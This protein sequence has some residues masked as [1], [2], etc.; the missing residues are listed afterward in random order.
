[1]KWLVREY[2][3]WINKYP[4]NRTIEDLVNNGFIILDKPK[5]LTSRAVC[6]QLKMLFNIKKVGHVGTLDQNATGVLPILLNEACKLA[7][8]LKDMDKKY[9]GKM[10][11]HKNVKT[12]EIE[13]VMNKFIGKIKQIPPLRSAVKR[14][15]RIRTIYEMKILK[16]EHKFITF[17][18]HCEAGT[19]IRKLVSDIGNFIGGAHLQELDRIAVNGFEKNISHSLK[20]VRK[21]WKMCKEDKIRE[22]I[23]PMEYSLKN[24]KKVIVKSTA[25]KNIMNGS[26]IYHAGILRVEESVKK[27]D[28]VAVLSPNGAVIAIGIAQ[29]DAKFMVRQ[30]GLMIK[31]DRVI[32][33]I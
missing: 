14:R 29:V 30:R 1:M 3:F 10:Y 19:Y 11:I 20:E 4:G 26:P 15:I 22:I 32:K 21:T 13:R 12:E 27:G 16:K 7:I 17:Y 24:V 28:R 18:V 23:L 8:L 2:E 9:I 25:I 5:G 6:E 31:T 33:S